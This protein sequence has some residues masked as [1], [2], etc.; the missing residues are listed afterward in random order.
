MVDV[1][2]PQKLATMESAIDSSM[3]GTWFLMLS[4]GCGTTR[5]WRAPSQTPATM[6]C[7][8][9]RLVKWQ[10]YLFTQLSV[11]DVKTECQGYY[12]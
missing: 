12:E 10:R 8:F 6:I 3:V 7:E 4:A 9:V 11:E 1:T 2:G 5:S